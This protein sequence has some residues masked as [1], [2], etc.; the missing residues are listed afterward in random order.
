RAVRVVTVERGVDPRGAALVAFGGAGPMHAC[1]I[2]EA[3]G[4][5]AVIVPARA[6][7]FSAVGLLCSP[8]AEEVVQS[9]SRGTDVDAID[10]ALDTLERVVVERVRAACS[11]GSP[12]SADTEVA[13][14]RLLD[15]RYVGQSHE[16]T[17][18]HE[19]GA[20]GTAAWDAFH[21]VHE[22]RNGFARA[23]VSVEVI[24]VRVRA[25]APPALRVEELPVPDRARV[26]G[27]QVVAELD[28]TMW[29]PPGWTA[30]PGPTGAWVI[31]RA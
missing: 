6:G 19:S 27:P 7:V 29:V 4:M 10:S 22:Q 12:A 21:D 31:T 3:L 5:A 1:A 17:V 28:C 13:V 16:L 18:V 24:A 11:T 23:D 2:A 26:I 30:E 14:E 20:R 8:R 25:S 9:W 15:C